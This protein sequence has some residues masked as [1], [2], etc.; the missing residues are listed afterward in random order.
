MKTTMIF[1]QKFNLYGTFM[2]MYFKKLFKLFNLKNGFC[3]K[4]FLE[5]TIFIL[6]LFLF[7]TGYLQ[8]GPRV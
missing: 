3:F 7:K 5:K 2:K 8:C 6:I 4:D 1:C